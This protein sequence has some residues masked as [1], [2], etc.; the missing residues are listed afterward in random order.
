MGAV[1]ADEE[2]VLGSKYGIRG[3]PTIKIF[4]HQPKPE[5]YNGGRTAQAMADAALNAAKKK[6]QQ[7]LGGKS[8][9][10]SGGQVSLQ[11]LL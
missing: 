2:K 7:Q 6:V 10:G 9:G 4:N 3:F 1:N 8:S 11:F 5:D